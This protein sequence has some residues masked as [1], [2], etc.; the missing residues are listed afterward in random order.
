MTKLFFPL[1][2]L[3]FITAPM[4]A[5]VGMTPKAAK[6]KIPVGKI[7]KIEIVAEL[8]DENYK[9]S[10]DEYLNLARLHEEYNI[11][12]LS[13][14]ITKEPQLV[15]V[16]DED[17][18]EYYELTEEQLNE[19]LTTYDLVAEKL[20][21]LGLFTRFGGKFI[22]FIILFVIL[23]G[24]YDKYLKGDTDPNPNDVKPNNI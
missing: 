20:V 3:M 22:L 24:V 16:T 5:T 15:L 8:N 18:L 4:F 23:Y 11:A 19:I 13:A 2:A 14:W 17:S 12:W 1:I 10:S 7:E 6:I 9:N 21:K